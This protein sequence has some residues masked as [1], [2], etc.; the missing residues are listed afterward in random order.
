ME[1][2]SRLARFK[3]ENKELLT[4]LLFEAHDERA[5]VDGVKAEMDL[6]FDEVRSGGNLYLA[7]KGLR[8]ILRQINKFI[9]FA[10][11]KHVEVELL[12]YFLTKVRDSGI[13]FKKNTVLVN[14]Y[15]MQ[16]KKIDKALEGMHED[17]QY[18]YRQETTGLSIG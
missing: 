10:G 4:Y 1:L 2:C 15:K 18:D 11:S 3:K 8:K 9:R 7:K 5:Y 6:L 17:L 14:M 12:I 13:G 16:L